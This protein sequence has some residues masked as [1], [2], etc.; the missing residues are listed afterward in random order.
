MGMLIVEELPGEIPSFISEMAEK[1]MVIAHLDVDLLGNIQGLFNNGDNSFR[2]SYDSNF[3][4]SCVLLYVFASRRVFAFSPPL[5]VCRRGSTQQLS[6][7]PENRRR[8]CV[9]NYDR[10]R[11][12]VSTRDCSSRSVG[13]LANCIFEHGIILHFQF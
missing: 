10:Q 12:R 4:L 2:L 7:S 1:N 8:C 11:C 6:P 13:A 5:L 3:R 9:R